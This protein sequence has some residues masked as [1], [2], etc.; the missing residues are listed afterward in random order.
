[1]DTLTFI[2]KLVEALVWPGAVVAVVLLLKKE[3]RQLVPLLRKLKAGPVEAEFERE[4]A[5]LEQATPPPMLPPAS[6]SESSRKL[7]LFELAKAAPRSAILQAWL[8]VEAV[9]LRVVDR[10]GLNVPEYDAHS[11]MAAIRTIANSTNLPADWVSRYYQLR[12]LR[13][14][15]A[16]QADFTPKVVSAA[17]YVELASRLH[18]QLEEAKKRAS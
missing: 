15:V 8:D 17:A 18:R 5:S 10:E 16:H 1:M 6:V 3:L 11:P 2:A 4:V 9:A 12:E 7:E 14:K 13:D